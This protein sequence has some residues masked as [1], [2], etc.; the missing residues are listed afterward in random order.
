MNTAASWDGHFTLRAWWHAEETSGF[1]YYDRVE[2]L[3][4]VEAQKMPEADA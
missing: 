3:T 1:F 4:R 2:E